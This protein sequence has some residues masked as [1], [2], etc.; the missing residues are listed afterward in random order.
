MAIQEATRIADMNDNL[1]QELQCSNVRF[2]F[3]KKDG[4]IREALGTMQKSVIPEIKGTGRP[5]NFDLQLYYDLD[6]KSFRSFK[7]ANLISYFKA[8]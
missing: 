2:C 1:Y 8:I 5:L 7:K 4:T 3:K 6:C